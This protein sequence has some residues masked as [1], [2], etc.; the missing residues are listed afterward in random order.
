V[1]YH[2]NSRFIGVATLP[3]HAAHFARFNHQSSFSTHEAPSRLRAPVSL[4]KHVFVFLNLSLL[5]PDLR[6]WLAEPKPHSRC[7]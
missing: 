3:Q 2:W 6:E 4:L 7:L 5:I 1:R